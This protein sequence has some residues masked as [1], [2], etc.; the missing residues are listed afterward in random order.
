MYYEK[1]MKTKINTIIFILI[2]ICI[3]NCSYDNRTEVNGQT[4]E[5]LSQKQNYI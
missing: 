4:G 2:I 5:I 1:A 3:I